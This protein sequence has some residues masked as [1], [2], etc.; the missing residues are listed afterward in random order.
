MNFTRLVPLLLL[1]TT[2]ALPG[3]G[4]ASDSAPPDGDTD[5]SRDDG[6]TSRAIRF[7]E[8]GPVSLAYREARAFGLTVFEDSV[9]LA[10]VR[11]ELGLEEDAQDSSLLET[12]LTT[13]GEGRAVGTLVAGTVSASFFLRAALPTG[14][15]TRL[16]VQTTAPHEVSVTLDPLYDGARNV[17]EYEVRLLAGGTCP[18]VYPG[19][20]DPLESVLTVPGASPTFVVGRELLFAELRVLAEGRD[21]GAVLTWGCVDR[22]TV[23]IAGVE[24][25]PVTLVDLPWPHPGRHAVAVVLPLSTLGLEVVDE[26]FAPFAGLLAGER[27]DGEFVVDGLVEALRAAGNTSVL[28]VLE[29]RRP[30]DGLD[31]AVDEVAGGFGIS[32]AELYARAAEFLR[33]AVFAGEVELGEADGTGNGDAV[34][35]WQTLGD[36]TTSLPLAATGEPAVEGAARTTFASDHIALGPHDLPLS[37]GRVLDLV[38]SHVAEGT[39]PGWSAGFTEWLGDELSCP[40]VVDALTVSADLVAVCD[41]TCLL[42]LCEGWRTGL[43]S[44]STGALTTAESNHHQL[45]VVST[46]TFLDADGRLLSTGHCEGSIDV[47]WRGFADVSLTG[48]WAVAPELLP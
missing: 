3:C 41:S 14:E 43:V 30:V 28:E 16:E 4:A 20:A 19:P 1:F 31:A 37:L 29:S 8:E 5:A 21:G 12:A 45:N 46:C 39:A 32:L 11:V 27:T 18:A 13:D 15:T 24:R 25:L 7:D 42:A 48:T 26:A 17:P 22:V 35:L 9:P 2:L 23:S 33:L 38:L 36:G 40:A 6:G 47:H 10:G 34:E 44:E